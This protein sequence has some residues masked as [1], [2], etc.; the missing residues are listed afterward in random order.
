MHTFCTCISTM[1]DKF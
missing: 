1:T